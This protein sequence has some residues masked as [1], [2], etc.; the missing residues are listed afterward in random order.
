MRFINTFIIGGILSLSMLSSQALAWEKGR[1]YKFPVLHTNDHHGRF[2]HNEQGE[3]APAA[4][5][6][7]DDSTRH[8]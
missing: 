6:T 4:H 2:R 8:A 1:G 5:K 7:D 3:H